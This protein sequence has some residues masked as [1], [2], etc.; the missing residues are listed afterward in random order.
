MKSLP[1]AIMELVR[2][3]KPFKA[4]DEDHGRFFVLRHRAQLAQSS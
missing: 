1:P 3:S 4:G 2:F